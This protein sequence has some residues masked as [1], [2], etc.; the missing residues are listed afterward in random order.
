MTRLFLICTLF[1]VLVGC[2][3]NDS[4]L[5]QSKPIINVNPGN[6]SEAG[7]LIKTIN[8]YYNLEKD[9]LWD[10]TYE[11]RTPLFRKVVSKDLYIKEM[12]ED[13]QGWHLVGFEIVSLSIEN[14]RAVAKVFREISPRGIKILWITRKSNIKCAEDTEWI[15]YDDTWF[16]LDPAGRTHLNLNTELV[17]EPSQS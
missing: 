7:K 9:E 17:K 1:F 2:Q 16:A 10:K 15:K 14:N 13:N 8:E 6:N 3:S 11:Y 5:K 4:E 12:K